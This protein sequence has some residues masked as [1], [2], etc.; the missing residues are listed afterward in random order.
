MSR[1]IEILNMKE[2][3]C[4]PISNAFSEQ[5]W[6]KP[7]TQFLRY[8]K[9]SI[10]GERIILLAKI[11]AN[12]A[13]YVTI[14]WKS[15]NIAFSESNIPEIV[16]LN[17]LIKY[18]RMGIGSALLSEAEEIISKRS[19]VAGIGVGITSDYGDAHI[20]YIK[21]GYVPNGQGICRDGKP[22]KHGQRIIVDDKLSLYLVKHL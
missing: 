5:G 18:Q 12:Y 16:D 19:N 22:I 10:Q 9:E 8:M 17:V 1:G 20:L 15:D 13:G 2:S 4:E 14:V 6:N 7:T 11:D 3:D 21:R